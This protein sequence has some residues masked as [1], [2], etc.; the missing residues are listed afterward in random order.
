QG[1]AN[2]LRA[3][4]DAFDNHFAG[5]IV[6]PPGD[7]LVVDVIA[8]QRVFGR[9]PKAVAA[10]DAPFRFSGGA[11]LVI[12]SLQNVFAVR[13]FVDE[14]AGTDVRRDDEF[15]IVV[16]EPQAVVPTAV[17]DNFRVHERSFWQQGLGR[18]RW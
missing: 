12:E 16:G 1:L 15:H 9:K 11:Q 8:E 6:V 7:R 3:V 14:D 2:A 13:G 5:K 10:A 17:G 4:L 18:E